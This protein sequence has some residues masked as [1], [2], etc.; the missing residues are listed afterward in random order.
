[1]TGRIPGIPALLLAILLAP[2]CYA[3]RYDVH[4]RQADGIDIVLRSVEYQ[5]Q[6][7]TLRLA[8]VNRHGSITYRTDEHAHDLSYGSGFSEEFSFN[9]KKRIPPGGRLELDPVKIR[10]A[11]DHGDATITVRVG[12]AF[13]DEREVDYGCRKE[14]RIPIV[15]PSG[16]SSSLIRQTP[17]P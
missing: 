2:G 14:F 12:Q 6:S 4:D 9:S 17:Q 11:P 10:I 8:I 1:M 7:L 3:L 16:V 5:E 13:V 15:R